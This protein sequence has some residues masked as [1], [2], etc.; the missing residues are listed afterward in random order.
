METKSCKNCGIEKELILFP[1]T[2]RKSGEYYYYPSCKLCE[3]SSKKKTCSNYYKKNVE[4]IL[5]LSN[6]KYYENIEYQHKRHN[7]GK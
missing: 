7:K 5:S 1:R 3:F 6:K 2:K 4:K